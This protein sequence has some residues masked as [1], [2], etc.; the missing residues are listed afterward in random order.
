MKKLILK[1]KIRLVLLSGLIM[2]GGDYLVSYYEPVS[3]FL[4]GEVISLLGWGLFVI[5]LDTK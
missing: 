5:A 1:N 2:I 4:L 3:I